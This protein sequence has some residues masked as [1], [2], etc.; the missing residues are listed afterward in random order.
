MSLKCGIV[1]FPNV[2]K[3]TL[4]NALTNLNINAENYPFCTIHPNF[5]SVAIYDSRLYK[6]AKIVPTKRIINTFVEFV[7]IAGLIEGASKGE[8]LGNKF[9]SDIR[10]TD[11]IVHMVRCFESDSIIHVRGK[12]SPIEDI[13]IINSELVL[14]DYNVCVKVLNKIK[15]NK[16]K[17]ILDKKKIEVLE[18]CF[19]HLD[20]L[21]M[22]NNLFLSEEER[23]YIKEFN[24]LTIKPMLYVANV[25][26]NKRSVYFIEQI[27]DYFNT[28]ESVFPILLGKDNNGCF[29]FNVN[30]K[31]KK[32]F[33][34]DQIK[35]ISF[36]V[37]KLLNLHTF[38]TVGEKEIKSWTIKKNSTV[39][40]AARK[41][42]S[43]F[44][45]GFIKAKVISFNDF[46]SFKGEKL[47][48]NSGKTRIEGKDYIVQDGDILNFLFNI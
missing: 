20:N 30:N 46:I 23:S 36:S 2:G 18:K 15:I 26:N 21:S 6:L 16:N 19:K 40:E 35:D 34:T 12:I 1:G 5:G 28:K 38:F 44:F 42:H 7:D 17:N 3:S 10:N 13:E 14:S 48:K 39:I 32:Q 29:C 41:I 22:L 8:G 37:L 47:A 27:N 4:F 9:L 25:N 33:F 24:F 31:L 43:D 45:R 11:A